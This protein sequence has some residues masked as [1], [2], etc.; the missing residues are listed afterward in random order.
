MAEYKIKR[1][2]A[3]CLSCEQEIESKHRHDFAR[4]KCGNVFV[5]GGKD[6]IRRG[7]GEMDKYVDTSI[8]EEI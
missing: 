2:S 3:K 6:Y 1:N 7:V 4:C 8:Y 5:D